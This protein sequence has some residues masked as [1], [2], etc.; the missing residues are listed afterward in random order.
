MTRFIPDLRLGDYSDAAIKRDAA[1]PHYKMPCNVDKAC[2]NYKVSM[3]EL[4]TPAFN[5]RG[6]YSMRTVLKDAL[7]S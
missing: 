1:G 3:I 6:L 7:N 4:P 2:E 5:V